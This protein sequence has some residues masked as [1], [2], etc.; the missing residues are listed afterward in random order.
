MRARA[1]LREPEKRA[2]SDGHTAPVAAR[3]SGGLGWRIRFA[4]SLWVAAIESK[5]EKRRHMS[6]Y[7]VG[8]FSTGLGHNPGLKVRPP[9]GTKGLFVPVCG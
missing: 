4:S 7:R 1:P 8:P 6:I 9:T 5:K 3:R 2:R